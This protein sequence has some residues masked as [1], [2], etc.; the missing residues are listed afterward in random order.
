[1]A[2]P[3]SE[4]L[5]E[6]LDT[7]KVKYC[8]ECG[9]CTASCPMRELI[10][11]VYNPRR[12]LESI[13]FDPKMVLAAPELWLCAW[14]YRCFKRCPQALKLPEIFLSVRGVAVD[15]G[16]VRGLEKAAGI[17]GERLPLPLVCYFVCLHPERAVANRQLVEKM[18]Q[19]VTL[20]REKMGVQPTRREKIAVIGSGPAGL[21]AAYE[22]ARRGYQV[23]VFESLP[24]PGGML[25]K[26]IPDYR[27]PK[28]VLDIEVRRI[29]SLG[30]EIKTNTT[31]GK[32][33]AFDDI[34]RDGYRAIFVASGAHKSVKPGLEGEDLAGVMY[35][36]DFLWRT[37]MG[38]KVELGSKV[39]VIGGGN[40]AIDA[41]RTALR[42][43]AKETVILYRRSRE[44]MPANP[45]EVG[46]AE[47]SNVRIRFLVAPKRFLG[48]DDAVKGIECIR[49]QLG[50]PDE[51]GRRRP[52]PV[53]GSEFVMEFDT[54]ILAIGERPD[55]SFL[56]EE[57]QVSRGRVAVD[58]FTMETTMPGVFAGGDVVTGPATVI[59]A[60]VA[61][62]RAAE[63]IDRYVE[64]EL[65]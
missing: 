60:I 62:V 7:E 40:V 1:M 43:G 12:L 61:G 36:L 2:A 10:P 54:V 34:R 38:E 19:Q 11:D 13:V 32:D 20:S 50:E 30:V 47:K 48:E 41:A 52:V 53:E 18:A 4:F 35:A 9:I 57:I 25:R 24:K 8:Y 65:K 44:E 59:E 46:E 22:L 63:S 16:D 42:L 56:P 6:I 3:L 23:T 49:T 58:P 28:E 33:L 26:C 5:R 29:K 37:N 64:A 45:W 31:I 27:L 55:L 39:A 17:I 15:R 51:T 14:C 21:T